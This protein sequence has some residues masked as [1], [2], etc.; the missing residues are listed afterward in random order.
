LSCFFG[1]ENPFV[2]ELIQLFSA[3]L[4]VNID[5]Y[6]SRSLCPKGAF[7]CPL[8]KNSNLT[9]P[10]LMRKRANRKW[11]FERFDAPQVKKKGRL[12]STEPPLPVITAPTRLLTCL[13]P[14][15]TLAK[16]PADISMLLLP[17]VLH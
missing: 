3:G 1:Q 17:P 2:K 10:E 5:Y 16:R 4:A 14:V 7:T 9:P 6:R 13:L 12:V 11:L 8:P 15:A